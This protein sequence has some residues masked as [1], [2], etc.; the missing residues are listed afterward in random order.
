MIYAGIDP[1]LTGSIGIFD[2]ELLTYNCYRIPITKDRHVN[3]KEVLDILHEHKP[4]VLIIEKVH[5]MPSQG[6]T[7]MFTFGKIYGEL[8][9]TLQAYGRDS[10][11]NVI[12]V[13]PV[14]WKRYH[15]ILKREKGVVLQLPIKVPAKNK[16]YQISFLE[17]YLMIHFIIGKSYAKLFESITRNDEQDQKI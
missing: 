16:I 17:I 6:V 13:S 10:I 8:F 15:G 7:S 2:T 1:G 11:I 3:V 9:A 12:E 14:I 4:E 5:A